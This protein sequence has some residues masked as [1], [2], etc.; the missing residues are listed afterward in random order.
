MNSLVYKWY[1]VLVVIKTGMKAILVL[2]LFIVAWS[3]CPSDISLIHYWLLFIVFFRKCLIGKVR[4][5]VLGL[6]KPL[7]KLGPSTWRP[8]LDFSKSSFLSTTLLSFSHLKYLPIQRRR[9][10]CLR[11]SRF[12]NFR[13]SLYELFLLVIFRLNLLWTIILHPLGV[14]LTL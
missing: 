9:R 6:K 7:R 13:K 2:F 1:L 11:R 14:M 8:L 4:L 5:V 12:A 3:R 10:P